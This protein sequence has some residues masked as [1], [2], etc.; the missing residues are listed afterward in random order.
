MT[1]TNWEVQRGYA[2]VIY[3]TKGEKSPDPPDT[4][5]LRTDTQ[6]RRVLAAATEIAERRPTSAMIVSRHV[7]YES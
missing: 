6:F 4:Y 1:S 5:V 2:S 3:P 7:V